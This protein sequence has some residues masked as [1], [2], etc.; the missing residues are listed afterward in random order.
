MSACH[1]V[2]KRFTALQWCGQLRRMRSAANRI[3]YVQPS[4]AVRGTELNC[5]ILLSVLEAA[6]FARGR[7]AKRVLLRAYVLAPLRRWTEQFK[8]KDWA[9]ACADGG[10]SEQEYAQRE[11]ALD[12]P[13]PWD[14][15]DMLVTKSYLKREFERARLGETTPDCRDHC[16]GCFGARYDTDCRMQE[17]TAGGNV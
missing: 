6:F 16:N 3:Y 12:E 17:R 1:I 10:L 13:L 7:A 2:P 4:R 11:Y 9:Q 5:Q 14:F 15:V 8:P